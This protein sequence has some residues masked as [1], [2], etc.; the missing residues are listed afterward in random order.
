MNKLA[1]VLISSNQLDPAG[2]NLEE[3][4]LGPVMIKD[5]FVGPVHGGLSAKAHHQPD[6]DHL[7]RQH[8]LK[9]N[10]TVSDRS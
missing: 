8:W 6:I 1:A 2:Y 4:T 3:V 7:S 10:R 5:D 9:A